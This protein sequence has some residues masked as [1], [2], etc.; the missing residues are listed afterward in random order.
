M[1]PQYRDRRGRDAAPDRGNDE[2]IRGLL[3]RGKGTVESLDLTVR[4]GT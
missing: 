4:N 3:L 1:Q 2:F